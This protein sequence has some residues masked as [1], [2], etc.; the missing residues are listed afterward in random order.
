MQ[1]GLRFYWK[2]FGRENCPKNVIIYRKSTKERNYFY[3]IFDFTKK[4]SENLQSYFRKQLSHS[5]FL[6]D[7]FFYAISKL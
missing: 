3:T 7:F 6:T 5:R 2:M 4:K 1:C